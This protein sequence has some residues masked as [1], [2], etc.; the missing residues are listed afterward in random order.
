MDQFAGKI[1]VVTGGASGIGR[2]IC[3]Y[4]GRHGA[5]VVVADRSLEGACEVQAAIEAAG[6]RAEAVRVEVSDEA[7]VKLL[8]DGVAERHGRLDYL[9][10]NAGVSVNG[11]FIDVPIDEWRRILGVN[12]WG[13]VY[14]CHHAYPL[15]MRQG[16]G[17]IVNTASLAGL[18]PGGLTTPYS[19]SKHAVV[20]FSLTLRSEARLYGIR[21]SALCP[22]YLRTAIQATTPNLS[23]YLDS[24]KNRKM[25]A[26]MK[27]LGPDD[28]I[29][30]I[31]RGVRRNRGVI[32]APRRHR[33]YW[34]LHRLFP[35]FMPG[36]FTK[37]IRRLKR[38]P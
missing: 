38:N 11:E 9:F 24:Q 20:G 7:S 36:M 8:V 23:A 33:I 17:H 29:E 6:G 15:M 32:V 28:C 26:R 18:I 37:I 30:Q 16:S 13:V 27:R 35:E 2:S 5:T 34:C 22:G 21:V 10:N 3:S 25:D 19:A 4:L 31:M 12:L 1:A 14:G